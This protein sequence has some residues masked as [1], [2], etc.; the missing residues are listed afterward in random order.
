MHDA[1]RAYQK[2]ERADKALEKAFKTKMRENAD[3]EPHVD[4]LTKLYKQRSRHTRLSLQV[5]ICVR[6]EYFPFAYPRL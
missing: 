1:E 6:F 4:A 2:L 5:C 3:T